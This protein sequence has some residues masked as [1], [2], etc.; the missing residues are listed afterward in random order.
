VSAQA[1]AF[2]PASDIFPLM[3]GE[4]LEDLAQDIRE[5]GLREPITLH[6][7]GSIL[8][9]RNRYRACL[10]VGIA[11]R[12]VTWED[13]GSPASFVI[14]LNLKRRHLTPSQRSMIGHKAM[15]LLAAEAKA[16]MLAGKTLGTLEPRG[17]AHNLA[18]AAVGVSGETV[19]R[20]E[21]V[22]KRGVPELAEKVR[23]GE[24]TVRRAELIATRP[25]EE[26]RAILAGS[27]AE[28]ASR[29]KELRS[30]ARREEKPPLYPPKTHPLDRTVTEAFTFAEMALSQLS[31]IR[32]DDPKRIEQLR[33]VRR[34]IDTQ[35]AKEEEEP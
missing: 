18:G 15:P 13:D 23:N 5:H 29:T 30:E 14:S 31:R 25:P 12:F 9:G 33:R 28:I 34:W 11:P 8:D 17:K 22:V 4:D 26:Q 32:S 16:R 27:K 6:S 19:R 2:H 20:A 21:V 3:E 24:M 7:D 35:L 10:R 1:I